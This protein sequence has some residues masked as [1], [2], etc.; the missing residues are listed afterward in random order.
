MKDFQEH[1]NES[2]PR[3]IEVS[4][5]FD[6]PTIAALHRKT[7]LHVGDT[8]VSRKGERFTVTKIYT[9]RRTL[10]GKSILEL[11]ALDIVGSKKGKVFTIYLR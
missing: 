4:G 2:A 5:K 9:Q 7:P 8:L 1:L 10:D 11:P 6:Q 3:T